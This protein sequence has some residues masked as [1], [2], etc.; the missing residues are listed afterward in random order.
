MTSLISDS[1]RA[2]NADLHQRIPQFGAGG[3]M[4]AE[5][6][7]EI[8]R[9]TRSNTILD[10]GCGKSSLRDKLTVNEDMPFSVFEYD[11]AIAGKEDGRRPC[12]MVVCTDVMEHIEPDCLDAVLDDIR[13]LA[14]K[15]IFLT[16]ATKPAL[17]VLA[18]GRNAHL[19]QQP[20]RWWLPKLCERWDLITYNMYSGSRGEFAVVG[21][22]RE[23]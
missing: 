20:P 5:Y 21:H 18:D 12:D 9:K 17:K 2:L 11:P 14:R 23:A 10:Y 1:Y 6:V 7:S 15:A 13:A 3:S 22:V 8:A 19:I 4:W 16:I